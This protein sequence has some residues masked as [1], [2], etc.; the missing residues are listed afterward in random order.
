MRAPQAGVGSLL[1]VK[2]WP[3][4]LRKRVI[5]PLASVA[6]VL[7]SFFLSCLGWAGQPEY[8]IVLLDNKHKSYPVGS[9]KLTAPLD[10]GTEQS[11]GYELQMD[12]SRFKDFFLSMKEFKCLEG[13]ELWCFVPYP[14]H[15]PRKISAADLTWL[16]QDLMFMFKDK[17]SF[18]ANLWNGVY[19]PLTLTT[20]GE[21]KGTAH[22]VDLNLIAAPPEPETAPGIGEFDIEEMETGKRWLPEIR[23]IPVPGE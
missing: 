6:L 18:G 4:T 12:H 2:V 14:Y 5:K 1:R 15:N 10:A 3:Q 19:Y 22:A 8:R 17:A 7:T 20:S 16:E 11:V 21:I 23:L 13:P 9:L